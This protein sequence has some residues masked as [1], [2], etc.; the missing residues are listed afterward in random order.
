VQ[1]EGSAVD[2]D[3]VIVA[4]G[5][6]PPLPDVGEGAF[7]DV[8]VLVGLGVEGDRSP[9]GGATPGP[10]G[11]LVGPLRDHGGDAASAQRVAGGSGAVGLNRAG[12]DGGSGYLDSDHGLVGLRD[13]VERLLELGGWNVGEVGVQAGVLCQWTQ[14]RVASSTSPTVFHGP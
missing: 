1:D 14:P 8:T 10:V 6:C 3:V 9:A 2:E 12:F 7:D 13:S 4:G 11:D 5:Q